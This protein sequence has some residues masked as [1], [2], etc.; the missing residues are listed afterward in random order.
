MKKLQN[1]IQE[2]IVPVGEENNFQ[3]DEK[4]NQSVPGIEQIDENNSQI[5]DIPEKNTPKN[6]PK[7]KKLFGFTPLQLL[8]QKLRQLKSEPFKFNPSKKRNWVKVRPTPKKGLKYKNQFERELW[9]NLVRVSLSKFKDK[10]FENA[11]ISEENLEDIES[12]QGELIQ[13]LRRRLKKM[14]HIKRQVKFEVD[15]M[16]KFNPE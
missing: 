2:K 12:M 8:K 13:K 16:G 11:E 3:F 9:H 1:Q 4:F 15:R 14:H 7:S 6:S 5:D 10:L